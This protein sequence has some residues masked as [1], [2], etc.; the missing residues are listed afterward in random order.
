MPQTRYI[1][2]VPSPNNIKRIGKLHTLLYRCTFG[3]IGAR[4]DGL[5]VLLLTTVGKKSGRPHCVPLPYFR[6]AERLL[7]VASYGGNARNPAWVSNIAAN[8]DVQVQRGPRR[9]TTRA[10]VA[11]G[12]ERERL[13]ANITREF[14]RYAVYQT[15]TSREI[16][17]IVLE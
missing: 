5:D 13:W 1:R 14:P 4:M 11:Q 16:P 12:A 2:W 17:V 6:D 15:R 3:L 9:W 8:P 7:V 10:H